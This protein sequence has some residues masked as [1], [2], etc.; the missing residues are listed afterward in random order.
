MK[1][2]QFT[3][4]LFLFTNLSITSN[5]QCTCTQPYQPVKVPAVPPACQDLAGANIV[6]IGSSNVNFTFDSFGEITGGITISGSTILRLNIPAIAGPSTCR[7]SLYMYIDND[8]DAGA[9]P[10]EWAKNVLYG[11]GGNAPQLN[12]LEV[13]VYNGCG[14]PCSAVYQTFNPLDKS[15]L[16]IISDLTANHLAGTCVPNV[17]GAGSYLTNFNEYTFTV[18]Y[19]IV[20][21]PAPPAAP[22]H[23]KPGQWQVKIHFDL[24]EEN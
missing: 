18:D 1:I 8:D 21:L 11:T 4:L 17:N 13:R 5:A 2:I 19:K 23:L 14:T 12:L 6:S 7:W 16:P 20:P 15:C 10:T 22:L 3:L 24:I 9:G